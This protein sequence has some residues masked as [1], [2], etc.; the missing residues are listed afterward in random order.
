ML[1]RIRFCPNVRQ[2]LVSWMKYVKQLGK[3]ANFLPCIPIKHATHVHHAKK[4]NRRKCYSENW[5]L[6]AVK[7]VHLHRLLT[8]MYYIYFRLPNSILNQNMKNINLQVV[9]FFPT[10]Q[11]SWITKP[12]TDGIDCGKKFT[13][14]ENFSNLKH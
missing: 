2:K 13:V 6:K 3:L 11:V 4:K 12:F 10:E 9:T 7:S 14:I 8:H 1:L 5:C